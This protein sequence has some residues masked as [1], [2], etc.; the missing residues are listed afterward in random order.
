VL[1]WA[2]HWALG[3][4]GQGLARLMVRARSAEGGD[5]RP[6]GG[7][8]QQVEAAWYWRL[9]CGY[10]PARGNIAIRPAVLQIAAIGATALGLVAALVLGVETL[11]KLIPL[12]YVVYWAVVVFAL[13]AVDRFTRAEV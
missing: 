3:W 7:I 6:T 1:L 11:P 5:P 12:A 13:V 9:A 4:A 8:E 10:R 2:A